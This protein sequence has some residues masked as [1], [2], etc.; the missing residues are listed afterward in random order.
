[1]VIDFEINPATYRWSARLFSMLRRLFRINLK[2]HEAGNKLTEGDIFLFNH[3]ARFETFIPQYFIYVETGAYCRSVAGADFFVEGD[4]FSNYLIGVGAVSND[5]PRLL[6]LLAGEILRG[7]KVVIFP[8]GG[9]VKDRRVLD[10]DGD[11]SVYSRSAREWRRHHTGA[12]V[13]GLA[14]DTFKHA[15]RAAADA[16]HS[17]RVDAWAEG[18]GLP[19]AAALLAAARKS[20]CI[21][22]ANITFWPVRI[23]DNL[24]R[25]GADTLSRGRLTRRLSEELLI[26]GNLL[27]KHTD[28]DIRLGEPVRME[29][30]RGWLERH[31]DERALSG[32]TA[33]DDCF[34]LETPGRHWTSQVLGRLMRGH[35]RQVR[36]ECMRRMYEGVTVN[37]SH[38]A[39]RLIFERIEAGEHEIPCAHFHRLLYLAVKHAQRESGVRL[40]RS[41]R[42]PETYGG[43]PEGRSRGLARFL[44]TTRNSAL[45]EQS[46]GSYRFLPKLREESGFDEVRLE[47]PVLVYANEVAPIRGVHDAIERAYADSTRL[48]EDEIAK[49]RFDDERREWAWDREAF[50]RE[51]HAELNAKETATEPG[52][53]F[54]FL[55]ASVPAPLGVVAVHGFLASPAEMHGL[56]RRLA[57]HDLPV[58][59]VRLKGHGTSPWDLRERSY[60]DWLD[61]VRRGY[62]I[63]SGLAQRI[64]V[65]GF[66]S[67][68]ALALLLAAGRPERLAGVIAVNVPLYFQNPNMK[69]VPLVHR[70][71]RVVQWVSS[72]EGV[73]PFRPN[74]SEH[75]HINYHH[76]PVHGLYELTRMVDALEKGLPGIDCPVHLVQ[77][78]RDPVVVP[79]SVYRIAEGL[80]RTEPVVRMVEAARHGIVNEDLGGTQDYTVRRVL[81]FGGQGRDRDCS[82]T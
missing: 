45:V 11:F 81:E 46:N 82:A 80:E 60:E 66:S 30:Y 12:A 22:P 6:P 25:Q 48:G 47:N 68:G 65:V 28:M 54:L 56:G 18:L 13:L 76:M 51:R 32:I 29:R 33:I 5:H 4:P 7:R 58:I 31:L 72:F 14:L 27:L 16:G 64:C 78:D 17:R 70:A 37:L 23:G 39:S 49:L 1:M 43:L 79:E 26:E 55:P 57:A 35:A 42:N 2:L 24:L 15:V 77:G 53:P 10:E 75:P 9:M 52:E 3:F 71:N 74:K 38:L 19:D 59:G 34:A 62:A 73:M 36:D 61:S 8:E 69:F 41:L 20:T 50:S 44:R 40:H 67:G 21:V 63:M